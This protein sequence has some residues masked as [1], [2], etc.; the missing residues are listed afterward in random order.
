LIVACF[1][2]C[3]FA[4]GQDQVP[5]E[6]EPQELPR[7]SLEADAWD[8]SA[9]GWIFIT[10]GSR[11]G[12]ATQARVGN[13]FDLDSKVLPI[14]KALVRLWDASTLGFRVVSAEES[15]TRF[16]QHDFIYHGNTYASGR[17]VRAEVGFLLLDLDYQYVWK[18]TE[19]LTVTPHLG[20]EYWGFSSHLR[21]VDSL[22][23]VDE[24]RT[25]SS[26]YWLGGV[27]LEARVSGPFHLS[28]SLLGGSN[29]ADRYFI[30]AEVG[31]SL[32]LM[33]S[34]AL[35]VAYHGHDVRFHTST[36]EANVIFHGPSAG[37]EISF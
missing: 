25:F 9:S 36:N 21:T 2:A 30:E 34:L 26:G 15:G 20:A 11:P 17:Q 32:H 28:L 7:F 22:P 29:G 37:L 23:L 24:K 27:D 6:D 8:A 33:P 18:A 19:D 16:A 4:W 31:A 13:A 1:L 12:T 14:G 5:A 3:S 10:R 35:K